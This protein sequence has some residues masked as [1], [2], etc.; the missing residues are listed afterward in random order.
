[1]EE[2]EIFFSLL[3]ARII[4]RDVNDKVILKKSTKRLFS[5]KSFC[6]ALEVV[7]TVIFPKNIICNP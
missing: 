5:V 7:K 3:Q 1:M 2:V 4:R 6:A